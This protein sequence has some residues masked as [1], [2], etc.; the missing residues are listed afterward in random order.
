MTIKE[1]INNFIEHTFHDEIIAVEPPR[2]FWME[3]K[4]VGRR[5]EGYITTVTYK[6]RGKQDVVSTIDN[7]HFQ[8]ISPERALKNA[9]DFYLRATRKMYKQKS[10]TNDQDFLSVPIDI[11]HMKPV[12]N[13]RGRIRAYNVPVKYYVGKMFM[14]GYNGRTAET[15]KQNAA[16][17][18]DYMQHVGYRVVGAPKYRENPQTNSLNVYMICEYNKKFNE[19]LFRNGASRAW[20]FWMKKQ[21]A[22]DRMQKNSELMQII[23]ENTK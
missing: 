2:E 13:A 16:S 22:V 17:W 19:T 1:K 23:N 6:Y 7:E 14:Y 4:D 10:G 5:L 12:Y 8:L 3:Y 15:E 20:Q 11:S 18:V 21:Y 9:N